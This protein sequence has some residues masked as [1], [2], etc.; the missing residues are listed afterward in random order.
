ML[1][2]TATWGIAAVSYVI[3]HLARHLLPCRSL[4]LSLS[5]STLLGTQIVRALSL[6][7]STIS[8]HVWRHEAEFAECS[9]CP[10]LLETAMSEQSVQEEL[11]QQLLDQKESLRDISEMLA[12][13]PSEQL[14]Q[15]LQLCSQHDRS[16]T[17]NPRLACIIAYDPCC[18]CMKNCWPDCKR[19]NWHWL[20]MGH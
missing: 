18:S 16:Y 15:V 8:P 7:R 6:S 9:A 11:S 3:S 17:A 4:S 2:R 14:Q 5:L 20:S 12:V 13:E 19:H 1:L 10:G